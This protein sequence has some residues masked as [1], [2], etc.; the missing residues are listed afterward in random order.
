MKLK[1]TMKIELVN[2]E[3]GEVEAVQE[4][5]MV[6]DAVDNILGSNLL[7][8]YFDSGT[9]SRNITVN[10]ELL[11]ICPN[12][13]GGILLFPDTLEERKDN[14]Y[15]VS[16]NY[17]TAYA[18]NDVNMGTD[19]ARGSMNQTES[20]PIERGYKFV[21]DFTTSQGN[22]TIAAAALTSCWGGKNVYG[23][24]TEDGTA[25]K[26]MKA[27]SIAGCTARKR[28]L[29]SNAIECDFEKEEIWSINCSNTNI[30]TISR[31]R[32]PVMSLCVNEKLNDSS[33]QELES[34]EIEPAVFGFKKNVYYYGFFLN[35]WD[36]FWYGFQNG[37]NS[38]GNASVK[39]IKI[40]PRDF[41][42]T[43][44]TWTLTNVQLPTMGYRDTN[45][46]LYKIWTRAC[47]RGGY[48]YTFNYKYD[49]I[50]KICLTNPS[51]VTLIPLGFT[52]RGMPWAGAWRGAR[53]S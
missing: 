34:W 8:M 1:G 38:S 44:G 41:S 45:Y 23:S 14:L 4:E 2:E 48:L 43:E 29:L 6:T 13:L 53:W 26:V 50:Y 22:G 42:Y 15:P 11:P 36:G 52:A 31:S 20:G 39:W 24:G 27:V 51:D 5:N 21:W 25:F 49:G 30:I 47:I 17:P 18:S 10:S 7:G 19:T 9:S 12:T 16:A 3:N 40:D 46:E 35:G 33:V 32:L 28:W 37:A